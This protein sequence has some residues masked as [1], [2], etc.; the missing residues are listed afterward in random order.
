MEESLIPT[1]LHELTHNH[2]GPHDAE[3]FRFLEVLT[4]EFHT[5]RKQRFLAWSGVGQRV[6]SG[7]RPG[8]VN[9]REARVKHHQEIIRQQQLLGRGGRLG[10]SG[11]ARPSPAAIA[12]VSEERAFPNS[13]GIADGVLDPRR[14]PSVVSAPPKAAEAS[15]RTAREP[16]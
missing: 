2:R 10:G 11:P 6:G 16:R 9:V 14:L 4:D 8:S 12:E 13:R 15:A 5:Y 1:M 7:L 3:F